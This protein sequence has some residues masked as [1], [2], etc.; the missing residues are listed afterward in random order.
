MKKTDYEAL[1]K[2][3]WEQ[4]D[5]VIMDENKD[6][7]LFELLTRL[8]DEEFLQ[9]IEHDD[10][11]LG[12]AGVDPDAI[13]RIEVRRDNLARIKEF[14]DAEATRKEQAL[15]RWIKRQKKRTEEKMIKLG[16]YKEADVK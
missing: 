6:L 16:L 7:G 14:Q 12:L 11:V 10:L 13:E 15:K 2:Q 3:L 5:D 8:G 1:Q 9:Q 4:M